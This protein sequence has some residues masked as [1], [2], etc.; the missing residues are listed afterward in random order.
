MQ[1]AW[2]TI[3]LLPDCRPFRKQPPSARLTASMSGDLLPG[4]YDHWLL[5]CLWLCTDLTG[6]ALW[7]AQQCGLL[8]RTD[9]TA[10]VK[11]WGGSGVSVWEGGGGSGN[12]LHMRSFICF[13]SEFPQYQ[14][15]RSLLL[16][17]PV[18]V[19]LACDG[20]EAWLCLFLTWLGYHIMKCKTCFFEEVLFL[21]VGQILIEQ[22]SAFGVYTELLL[23]LSIG[24]MYI[25]W[26]WENRIILFSY[27]RCLFA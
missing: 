5:L 18:V 6:P 16:L 7:V 19:L 26:Y 8:G 14:E 1:P 9:L 24:F 21:S 17:Q 15:K 27:W 23:F 10:L 12:V 2:N 3:Y 25:C 20:G 13:Y 11:R 22:Y 4:E